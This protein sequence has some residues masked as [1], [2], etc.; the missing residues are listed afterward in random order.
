[1]AQQIQGLDAMFYDGNFFENK[2]QAAKQKYL[3][4]YKTEVQKP[5]LQYYGLTKPGYTKYVGRRWNY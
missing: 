1:M 5:M 3:M 2:Y 4:T